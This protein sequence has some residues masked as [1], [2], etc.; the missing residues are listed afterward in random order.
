MTA[1][2]RLPDREKRWRVVWRLCSGRTSYTTWLTMSD[3]QQLIDSHSS[4]MTD[5]LLALQENGKPMDVIYR[6]PWWNP[7][8]YTKPN[9]KDDKRVPN[10]NSNR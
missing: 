3:A 4:L 7:K 1:K 8:H 6:G 9:P 5:E 2:N 10:A